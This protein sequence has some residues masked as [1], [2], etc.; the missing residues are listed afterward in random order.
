MN[1]HKVVHPQATTT[2]RVKLD[3]GDFEIG[4]IGIGG[5]IAK[6]AP[7]RANSIARASRAMAR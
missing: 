7:T 2:Y 6:G 5:T 3:E 1:L 4:S